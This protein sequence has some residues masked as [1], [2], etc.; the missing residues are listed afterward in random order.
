MKDHGGIRVEK[1][2]CHPDPFSSGSAVSHRENESQAW[3]TFL[4]CHAIS[5]RNSLNDS[6]E[7]LTEKTPCFIN[8]KWDRK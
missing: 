4:P 1:I 6:G 5:V 7:N 2:Q 8:K 3:K